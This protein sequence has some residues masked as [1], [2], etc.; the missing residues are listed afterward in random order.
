M[1]MKFDRL[2]QMRQKIV[3]AVPAGIEM[4]FM[5]HAFGSQLL[6]QL[7]CSNLKSIVVLITTIYVDGLSSY[8]GLVLSR[9]LERIVLFPMRN[10]NRV[11]EY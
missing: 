10:V 1:P 5:V 8:F 9:K 3:C 11:P 4:K 7:S 2:P 6:V